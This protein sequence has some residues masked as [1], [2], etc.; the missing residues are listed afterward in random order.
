MIGK[1]KTSPRPLITCG[2]MLSISR[3]PVSRRNGCCEIP[4]KAAQQSRCIIF[5]AA[6]DLSAPSLVSPGW[7]ACSAPWN[8]LLPAFS[9]L[10]FQPPVP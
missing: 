8:L 6:L 1:Q 2:M 5:L 7:S 3:L 9:A 4:K 10:S